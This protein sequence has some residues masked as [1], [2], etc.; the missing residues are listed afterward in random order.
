MSSITQHGFLVLAD[1]SGYTSFL[2]GTELEHAHEILTELLELILRRLTPAMSL[3]KLE[4][5][6]VFVYASDTR[7][8]HGEA[9]LD[10]IETTYVA[11]RDRQ[12]NM[13]HRTT[14]AC[15]ACRA[16]PTLDL[17]FFAH[18]GD[19]IIQQISDRHEMVGTD[20]N[21][22]HRLMK[23]HI[24][25]ATGWKGYALYTRYVLEH[26]GLKP[27][28]MHAQVENYE[29]LGDVQTYSTNLRDRHQAIVEA[30]RVFLEAKD[31]DYVIAQDFEASPALVWDWWNNPLN[32]TEWM[33]EHKN[34]WR[35]G[36]RLNGRS[37]V[38]ARNHCAHG[39]RSG[40]SIETITDWRPF[41]YVSNEATD[42]GM[43]FIETVVFEPLE[44]GRRTR[45]HDRLIVYFPFP[46]PQ[47]ARRWVV[48]ALFIYLVHYPQMMQRCADL[49][50]DRLNTGTSNP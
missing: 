13:H 27:E 18:H 5:D 4:G 43:R 12:I 10:L 49:L 17:K 28:G 44:D 45:L 3:A 33:S 23:N 29:H 21:L 32:R 46:L 35:V 7:F 50:H 38:G 26:V 48:R 9:L 24:S 42:G 30:R 16:I 31:A 39:D 8:T 41:D 11:F 19:F 22:V 20:V 36:T 14:C 6:A 2:A 37:G 25:E 40:D 47:F 34:V 1:I 15:S